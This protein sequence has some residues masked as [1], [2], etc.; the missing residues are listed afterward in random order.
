[1]SP[2]RSFDEKTLEVEDSARPSIETTPGVSGFVTPNPEKSTTFQ[3]SED[4]ESSAGKQEVPEPSSRSV[5]GWRWAL[6]LASIYISAFTYGLDTTIAAD[7][8]SAV[9]ETFHSVEDLSW[10]GTGFMMGSVATILPIGRAFELFDLKYNFIAGVVLFEIG[11]A[12]CGAAPNMDALI[13]G[14]VL[15]G[16][17]GSGVYVGALNFLTSLTSETERGKYISALGIFW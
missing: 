12:I 10:L 2:T 6:V 16:I 5:H 17:G 1:M 9:V 14:R 15:A 8:Q 3:P 4:V 13:V 11:S 7:V